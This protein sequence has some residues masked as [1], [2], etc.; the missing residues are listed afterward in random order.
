V[1]PG[2][3]AWLWATSAGTAAMPAAP[4]GDVASASPEAT[5][6]MSAAP[7]GDVASASPEA[8][9]LRALRVEVVGFAEEAVLAAL[10][11]RLPRLEVARHADPPGAPPDA[12]VRVSRSAADAG[13]IQVIAADGRAYARRFA[14]EVEQEVRVVATT[15]ANLLFAVEQGTLPPDREGVA[16]PDA[17]SERTAPRAVTTGPAE[18]TT[19]RTPPRPR[20][21]TRWEL[22]L[23]VH[24][25]AALAVGP[26]RAGGALAAGGGGLGLEV[27]APR[28]AALAL[29]LRG[30]GVRGDE[31][32][33]ARLRV[34][35]GAG[36]VL[37]RGRF[38]LPVLLALAVE[39]WWATL[40]GRG[41]PVFAG[42]A[43]AR[44]SPL[45]GGY[46]RV[47]PALRVALARGPVRGLRIGPRIELGGSFV[48]DGGARVAVLADAEGTPQV[49]LGGLELAVGVGAA[50]QFAAPG[51]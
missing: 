39:P 15:T 10:R 44:R 20:A 49:R 43:A 5:A 51:P 22:A 13:E 30:A 16:M 36:Y 26:P 21:A 27:R 45:I 24:G 48:V 50:L 9:E 19:P 34:A 18:G 32:G 37:R 35:V 7:A 38:E 14:V 29:E 12:F 3:I 11:L 8:T 2:L 47:E 46:L 25:A 6:A 42:A 41:A 4:A 1:R 23:A 33:A 40:G 31:V 28:G 17:P